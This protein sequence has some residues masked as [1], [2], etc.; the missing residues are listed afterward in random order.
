MSLSR[1]E[2]IALVTKIVNAEGTEE[3]L[4]QWLETVIRQVP[5]PQVSDLIYWHEPELT[6]DEIVDA[7][8]SYQPIILP[9]PSEN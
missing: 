5:H 4:D 8:L 3:E 9:P 2:L 1:Q 6:P 7:A